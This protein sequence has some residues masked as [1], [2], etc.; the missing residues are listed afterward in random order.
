MRA[1]SRPRSNLVA[2]LFDAWVDLDR[3]VDGLT[4]EVALEPHD[5]GSSFAWTIAHSANL[6]DRFVNVRFRK[7]A[8]HPYIGK[9]EFGFGA[10]GAADDWDAVREGVRE[11]HELALGYL[12]DLDDDDLDE[13]IPYDG[14]HRHLRDTGISLRYALFRAIAHHYFHI[15][16]IASKR[17]RLGHSVGDYP[18]KLETSL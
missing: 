11:V 3:V 16:E 12:S 9:D 6:V 4:V 18:G 13:V 10:D 1:G 15:G 5:G 7:I 2:L 8:R 17:D 14:S